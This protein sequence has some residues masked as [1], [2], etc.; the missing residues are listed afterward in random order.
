MYFYKKVLTNIVLCI[1][2]LLVNK[3][4]IKTLDVQKL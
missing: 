3:K 4:Y 2:I 1:T